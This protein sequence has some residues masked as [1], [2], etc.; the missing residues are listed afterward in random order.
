MKLSH[1]AA[2]LILT[3]LASPLAAWSTKSDYTPENLA[4]AAAEGRVVV[5]DF[6]ADWCPTC[7]KQ[8]QVLTELGSEPAL[9]AV[10]LLVVDFDQAA[11]LKSRLGVSK[12]STLVV[13]KGEQEIARATGITS[14]D[15]VRALIAK[16][17]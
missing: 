12:Q 15:D 9:Q 13:M 4:S 1:L 2:A 10:T 17:L 6:H 5:L 8:E 16:A 3:L 7:R 14:K 11:E